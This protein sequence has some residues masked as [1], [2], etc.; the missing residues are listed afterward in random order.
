ML[1]GL[2]D[3][4]RLEKRRASEAT[5]PLA[6]PARI[7]WTFSGAERC[8]HPTIFLPGT[9]SARERVGRVRAF[10]KRGW[11][12]ALVTRRLPHRITQVVGTT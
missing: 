12:T 10:E 2:S 1:H 8:A 6:T 5:L 3:E 9:G 7:L 4:F 11:S